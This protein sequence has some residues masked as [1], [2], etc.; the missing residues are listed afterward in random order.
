MTFWLF[1]KK[2]LDQKASEYLEIH[3]VTTWL[4]NNCNTH[5]AQYFT[6]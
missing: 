3:V 5:I 4:T 2:R 1:R 6:N